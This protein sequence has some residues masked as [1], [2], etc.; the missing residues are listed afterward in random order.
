MRKKG[1]KMIENENIPIEN[2]IF[3]RIRQLAPARSPIG[4]TKL[5]K[6]GLTL[7]ELAIVILVLGIIMGILYNTIDFGITDDAKKLAISGASKIIPAKIVQYETEVGPLDDRAD[8]TVLTRTT[9][10][11]RGVDEDMVKDPW[12][13]PYFIQIDEQQQKQVCSNGADRTPGG[14]DKN[15]D[16]C[17]TNKASWPKWLGGTGGNNQGP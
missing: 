3:R 1:K 14:E 13:Q 8:L 12:G 5:L 16:F 7:V 11:W 2:E 17:I 15:A 9:G 4:Y 10:S 6:K